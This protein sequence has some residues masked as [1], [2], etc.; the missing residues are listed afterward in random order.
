M[1]RSVFIHVALPGQE[2][3]AA[4]RPGDWNFPTMKV[5]LL[6]TIVC[7]IRNTSSTGSGPESGHSFG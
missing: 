6:R 3:G 7:V 5:G 1:F 4:D 2:P